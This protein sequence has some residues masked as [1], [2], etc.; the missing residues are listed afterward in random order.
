MSTTKNNTTKA[1]NTTAPATAKKA[2]P[3]PKAAEVK[4]EAKAEAKVANS[5]IAAPQEEVMRKVVYQESSQILKRD[6]APGETFGIG[7]SMPIY[8]L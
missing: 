8:Y 4:A 1:K 7:D 6:A 2:A 5:V 3:A